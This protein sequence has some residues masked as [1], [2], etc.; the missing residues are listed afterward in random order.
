MGDAEAAAQP[1]A[2]AAP[3]L[4]GRNIAAAALADI[5]DHGGH[6]RVVR[7]GGRYG[8]APLSSFVACDLRLIS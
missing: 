2:V 1:A 6:P 4:H 7:K 5:L 8:V 3:V